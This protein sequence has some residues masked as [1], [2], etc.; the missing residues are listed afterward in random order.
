MEGV[1]IGQ[2][3]EDTPA[4]RDRPSKRIALHNMRCT[5][6]GLETN[7]MPLDIQGGS[8][9]VIN[10]L[11]GIWKVL[12]QVYQKRVDTLINKLDEMQDTYSVRTPE[13]G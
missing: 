13:A 8:L 9:L 1:H 10:W 2:D 12:A 7:G 4:Y 3:R 6:W 11:C 5:Q